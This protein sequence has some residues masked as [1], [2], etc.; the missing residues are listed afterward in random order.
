[1]FLIV[2]YQWLRLSFPNSDFVSDNKDSW[3]DFC[4]V[5][6]HLQGQLQY[7]FLTSTKPKISS[8][9]RPLSPL[10]LTN[11][12]QSSSIKTAIQGLRM[13]LSGRVLSCYSVR[14][15]VH[16]LAAAPSPPH[17]IIGLRWQNLNSLSKEVNSRDFWRGRDLRRGIYHTPFTD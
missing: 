16:F 2:L 1:M 12:Y 3:S 11:L 7:S 4:S 9:S 6:T 10:P 17:K 13:L 14:S 15:W 5:T 8:C